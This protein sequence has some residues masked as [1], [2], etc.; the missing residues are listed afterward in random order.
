MREHDATCA[1]A[2]LWRASE[3]ERH[4]MVHPFLRNNDGDNDNNQTAT[5]DDHSCH[6]CSCYE[7]R[8][9]PKKAKRCTVAF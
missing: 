1:R 8:T 9:M 7:Q 4:F 6:D 5:T 3:N 2:W